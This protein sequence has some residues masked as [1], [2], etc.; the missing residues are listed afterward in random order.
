M[1]DDLSKH[2]AVLKGQ[3][4]S[5]LVGEVVCRVMLMPLQ[6][7]DWYHA[8]FL[9]RSRGEG[10]WEKRRLRKRGW[11]LGHNDW[12]TKTA[13][14][15]WWLRNS[16]VSWGWKM[17]KL[18][19]HRIF[20]GVETLDQIVRLWKSAEIFYKSVER[21]GKMER[22]LCGDVYFFVYPDT[23]VQTAQIDVRPSFCVQQKTGQLRQKIL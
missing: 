2:R 11:R 21:I 8:R 5:L 10:K 7:R 12:G 4:S 9:G 15:R 1:R 19:S 23:V 13:F 16:T 6:E 17:S 20:K 3:L 14:Q 22:W 18:S